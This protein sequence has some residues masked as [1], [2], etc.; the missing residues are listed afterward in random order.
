MHA[1]FKFTEMVLY[2]SNQCLYFPTQH[3]VFR[4]QHAALPTSNLTSLTE[5]LDLGMDSASYLSAS[6]R[7]ECPERLQFLSPR[8]CS[9]G[10]IFAQVPTQT[11]VKKCFNTY[12]RSCIAGSQVMRPLDQTTSCQI[13]LQNG[14]KMSEERCPP[15]EKDSVA[16]FSHMSSDPWQDPHF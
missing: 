4:S 13:S 6:P 8:G 14:R 11:H 10:N 3:H 5:P 12:T 15:A 16:F 1:Y 2:I 9:A 7:L